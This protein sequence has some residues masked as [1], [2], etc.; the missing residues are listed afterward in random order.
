[1]KHVVHEATERVTRVI[2][3]LLEDA[4]AEQLDGVLVCVDD[5]LGDVTE[6][7]YGTISGLAHPAM[8]FFV[9][10]LSER[11]PRHGQGRSES[12]PTGVAATFEKTSFVTAPCS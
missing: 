4:A 7:L 1:M 11:P 3:Q 8:A 9:G 6:V 10:A 2:E 5:F 12:A